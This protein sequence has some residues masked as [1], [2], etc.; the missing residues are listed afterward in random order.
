MTTKE[1]RE[2]AVREAQTICDELV[3]GKVR[4]YDYYCD[5][6]NKWY[7]VGSYQSYMKLGEKQE[8]TACVTDWREE[9]DSHFK[10]LPSGRAMYSL[11]GF[12]TEFFKF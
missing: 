2:R 7:L 12:F 9:M 1:T 6:A 10:M 5:E 8:V 11:I 4:V 3:P